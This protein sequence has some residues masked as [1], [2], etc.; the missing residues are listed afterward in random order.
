MEAPGGS[1]SARRGGAFQPLRE[2][3]FR[4]IWF[5]SVLSNFGQLILGV[6]AAWEMTRLTT[7]ASMVA[8]VQTAMMLPLML[9][10]V[11]AG[12]VAD[13]FDRRR[14][15]MAGLGFSIASAIVLTALAWFGLTSPWVL[16]GFCALIGAGVALY[17]PAWQ[18]S[19]SEQVPADEL[20]AAIALGS[21]SYNVARSFG[22]AVGGLIVLAAGAQAAF[23]IN[24]VCYIPLFAAFMIWN[25]RHVPS[26]LPPEQIHRAIVSGARY[27]FHAGPI[28]IVLLRAFL[29]GLAGASAAALAPLIAK[30]LLGG[31]ASTYGI[32]LGASGVGA[33]AGALMVS[34]LRT[35][36]GTQPTTGFMAVVGGLALVVTGFS[37]SVPLTCLALFVAGGAN[38]L[39]IALLNVSVQLAAPR[40][41]TA[42]ALSLFSSALTGGI[43]IGAVIWGA[44]ANTWSVDVA[45][46]ASGAALSVMPFLSLL[47][48]LPEASQADVEPVK[49]AN[50]PEVGLA[51][52][53]RSGPVVIEIDYDVDPAQARAFYDAMLAVQRTRLR[54]GGF[55]W[56]LAR[57][58]ANPALWTERYQCPTWGDY[59]RMRDRITQAD[60]DAQAL[61]RSF[62][63]KAG[64]TR[65]RRRLERPFGSVR[66]QADSPDPQ[67]G[68]IDYIGP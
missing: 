27:A 42:R 18:A 20:P 61:V 32:L 30:D 41:V 1:E 22:P 2:P 64:E 5:A 3:V 19:I 34:H 39:T 57:D 60:I 36:F 23:A 29:F 58:I 43:A 59:L 25:R 63:R 17:S 68:T 47:L 31:N 7:S 45:V 46:V 16:L 49:L 52:T 37:R 35:H 66:W 6:G 38:I 48:P 55:N 11:P 54:N 51:L 44:V 40:W 15:A 9:V 21:I 26:R 28:R 24:A 50:E 8:L 56:S 65:V 53:S 62:D 12:A 10:A 14:I 13:M 33:V 67:Q 4:R